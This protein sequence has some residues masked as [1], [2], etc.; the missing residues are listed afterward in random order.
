MRCGVR[1]DWGACRYTQAH[2][3]FS[4]SSWRIWCSKWGSRGA[5]RER[6]PP[7]S[8]PRLNFPPQLHNQSMYFLGPHHCTL[9]Q[10]INSS[11]CQG[12]RYYQLPH[13]PILHHKLHFV[14]SKKARTRMCFFS[15]CHMSTPPL[16]LGQQRWHGGTQHNHHHHP[17]AAIH[18]PDNPVEW[19]RV[20]SGWIQRA[21]TARMLVMTQEGTG[22]VWGTSSGYNLAYGRV[23]QHRTIVVR[24]VSYGTTLEPARWTEAKTRDY[25]AAVL[26]ARWVGI[27]SYGAQV[28]QCSYDIRNWR[29]G[30]LQL[31]GVSHGNLWSALE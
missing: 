26:Y 2:S 19:M 9:E 23:Q 13:L 17:W 16:P 31:D 6:H 18:L 10:L 28:Y 29:L 7:S 15:P 25:I 11:I 14:K 22:K 3:S 27:S 5:E 20:S 4:T 21:R 1:G 8:P 12:H 30:P 24:C